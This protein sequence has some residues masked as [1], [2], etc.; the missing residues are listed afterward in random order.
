MQQ[1]CVY[2][3]ATLN[4]PHWSSSSLWT[5]KLSRFFRCFSISYILIIK[6]FPSAT[7]TFSTKSFFHWLVYIITSFLHSFS[8]PKCWDNCIFKRDTSLLS[9]FLSTAY[10]YFHFWTV[11][12]ASEAKKMSSALNVLDSPF[13]FMVNHTY[14]GFNRKQQ[15]SGLHRQEALLTLQT[16]SPNLFILNSLHICLLL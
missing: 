12:G 3:S 16:S 7:F 15:K 14:V 4:K 1:H 9:P 2:S 6:P 13:P 10:I 5:F 8:F 11:S